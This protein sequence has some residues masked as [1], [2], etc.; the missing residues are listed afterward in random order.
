MNRA[1]RRAAAR[2]ARGPQVPLLSGVPMLNPVDG[3][4]CDGWPCP[5]CG[6]ITA[7]DDDDIWKCTCGW[8]GVLVVT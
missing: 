2:S 1:D 3:C 5:Y 4:V 8:A 7:P 6:E